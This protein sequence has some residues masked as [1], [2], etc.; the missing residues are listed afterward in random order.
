MDNKVSL[1]RTVVK[2]IYRGCFAV[3]NHLRRLCNFV[4]EAK[5]KSCWKFHM[6]HSVSS[7]LVSVI[8]LFIWICRSYALTPV[9]EAATRPIEESPSVTTAKVEKDDAENKEE[10]YPGVSLLFDGSELRPFEIGACLQARQ[11]VSLIAEAS[12]T[13]AIFSVQ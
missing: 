9:Y 13:S 4:S 1:T 10:I 3:V 11:P 12:A 2:S 5:Q 8:M 6:A 7:F